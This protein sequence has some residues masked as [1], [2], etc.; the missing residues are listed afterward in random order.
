MRTLAFVLA[1]SV[2]AAAPAKPAAKPSSAS[3]SGRIIKAEKGR[4]TVV[5]DAGHLEELAVS[6][7]TRVRCDG[8]KAA[9]KDASPEAC[10]RVEKATFD[11][12]TKKASSLVLKRLPAGE[13]GAGPSLQGEVANTDVVGG[14]LSVRLGGGATIDL[15]VAEGTKILRE[16]A[17]DKFEP[18]TLDAVKVGDRVEVHSKDWKTAEEVHVRPA[19]RP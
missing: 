12:R 6:A 14:K 16:V 17:E 10:A 3:L 2:A 4:I 9:L 11:A 8:K 13:H 18:M 19:P 5:D 7:K 1:S 15:K